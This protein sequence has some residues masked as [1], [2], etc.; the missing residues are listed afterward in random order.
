MRILLVTEGPSDEPVAERLVQRE[1]PDAK[2]D[3]KRFSAR[4]IAVVTR[5][6][7]IWLRAAH[8]GHYDLL[9]V[10]FDLDDSLSGNFRTVTESTRWK[11]LAACAEQVL[12][13]LADAGRVCGLRLAFM[14]P[15]QS[16]EAWLAWAVENEDGAQWET[17]HRRELKKKL[18]GD[19][20]RGLVSKAEALAEQLTARMDS[21]EVW[22]RSLRDFFSHLE[23]TA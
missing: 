15:C 14:A 2:V 18:F 4:G 8:F 20:P 11:D 7:E 22:P 3:R 23:S 17:V 16:T 5:Q 13:A 6:L 9:I 10:H 19:P 1:Y 12:S 21:G